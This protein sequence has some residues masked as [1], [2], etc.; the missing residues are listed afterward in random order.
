M[1]NLPQVFET[2]PEE[3][4]AWLEENRQNG[5]LDLSSQHK[6]FAFEYL[7]CYSHLQ[8]ADAVGIARNIALR[9]LKDPLVQAFIVYLNE[10]KEHYTLIDASFIEVQYLS[11][12]G[13]LIGEEDVPMVDK[14]GDCFVGRKFH[15]AEAVGALRD[16]AKSTKFFKEGSGQGGVN[17]NF[18][19]SALGITTV[20]GKVDRGDSDAIEGE[21]IDG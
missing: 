10:R 6:Q 21:V 1:S 12:Y 15:A 13:K 17:I 9:T 5:F 19:L 16:M 2:K 11:L 14:N 8:A 20:A 4:K 7:K 18:D 3:L